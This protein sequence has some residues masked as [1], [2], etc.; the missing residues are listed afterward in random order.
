MDRR[1]IFDDENE[2]DDENKEGEAGGAH[3]CLPADWDHPSIYIGNREKRDL[4]VVGNHP[5]EF[6]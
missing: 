1:L 6:N 3:P 5:N 2:R 4:R